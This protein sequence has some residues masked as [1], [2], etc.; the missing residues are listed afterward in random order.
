M[1]G[2]EIE[3]KAKKKSPY[4][5][6]LEMWLIPIVFLLSLLI[7]IIPKINF[8][9]NSLEKNGELENGGS[10]I[11]F[12]DVDF[13]VYKVDRKK[14]KLRLWLKNDSGDIYKNIGNLKKDIE[15]AGDEKLLFAMNAG[16]YTPKNLPQGLYKSNNKLEQTLDKDTS[17]Y[18]NFFMQ[19]N[20]VFAF[21]S[22]GATIATT[23]EFAKKE[24][25]F[26]N[27][28]Q[29]GPMLVIE[30]RIHPKFNET[31][32]SKYI[33]NGVGI[34]N[35]D[36]IIF[37]YSTQPVNLYHFADLFLTFLNC[38]NA[39]YLDGAIS[40]AYIPELS[41]YD[42]SGNLGPLIGTT[43]INKK[44]KNSKKPLKNKPNTSTV[45]EKFEQYILRPD[46]EE[47]NIFSLNKA[48]YDNYTGLEDLGNSEYK[49]FTNGGSFKTNLLPEGLLINDYNIISDVNM[50]E[51]NGNFYLKPN[52]IL[53]KK[54]NKYYI[55]ESSDF[56]KELKFEI[57]N[58]DS[59]IIHEVK[60]G[61]NLFGISQ[62]YGIKVKKLKRDNGLKNK[63]IKKGQKLKIIFEKQKEE[64]NTKSSNI[65]FA[66]QSGPLLIDNGV[67]HSEFREESPN[68]KIRNGVGISENGEVIFL[69]SK[70]NVNLFS[71]ARTFKEDY[72]CDFALCLDSGISIMCSN[73]N[74]KEC[75]E[76][77]RNRNYGYFIV[78]N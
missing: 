73:Q 15:K 74:K 14:E 43:I 42:L 76:K 48:Q 22:K 65:K 67:I 56:L 52:G 12:K 66:V 55:K 38:D 75:I 33:R 53:F 44:K 57:V 68:K 10:L 51:G 17:G 49:I 30:G 27:A 77:L 8:S 41:K 21:N 29:S 40:K 7:L 6:N 64:D 2:K 54:S 4:K 37:A 26:A 78:V 5:Y 24:K 28:T 16:M 25:K 61:E 70:N 69:L 39:L 47:L 36:N 63:I 18:G 1:K 60:N 34:D 72:N 23:T 9:F 32:K 58:R 45:S 35:E 3:N 50:N 20:G 19:P 46:K 71:F 59:S 11:A 62:K 31:S 13:Y